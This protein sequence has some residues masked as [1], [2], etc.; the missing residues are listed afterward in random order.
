MNIVNTTIHHQTPC[1]SAVLKF[2]NVKGVTY[3][4]RTKTN[5]WDNTLRR[6]GF[7]I[8]SR[9]SML[10]K[11]E[12]TVGAA[13]KRIKEIA[14]N[15]PNIIAFIV[16]VQGHILVLDTEGKTVVDTAPRKKD[17][18]KILKLVAVIR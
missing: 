3:N 8:R 14:D 2:F 12:G 6:A 11:K 4:A 16:R 5:V 15:E 17:K 1:A 7:S 10:R 13:R 18:R 9:M